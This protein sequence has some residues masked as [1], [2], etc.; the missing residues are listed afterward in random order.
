MKKTL[1]MC[2][3][4]LSSLPSTAADITDIDISEYGI[5]TSEIIGTI[6]APLTTSGKYNLVKNIQLVEK[7]DKIPAAKGTKFGLFYVINGDI[8]GEEVN[9]TEIVKFPNPGYRDPQ[10]GKLFRQSEFSSI[11]K[12]GSKNFVAGVFAEDWDLYPGNW[13][14]QLWH[15]NQK[16]AEK[17][18]F[19]FKP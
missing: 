14:I 5:Y 9:I 2:I 19:V 12:I 10:T 11:K 4:F 8:D 1:I 3:I 6:Y 15:N 17:S 13:Q 7:T 18:F 16:L